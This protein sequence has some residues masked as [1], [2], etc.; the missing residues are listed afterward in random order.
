[1]YTLTQEAQSCLI[2]RD[3]TCAAAR[4]REVLTRFPRRPESMAV[5]ISLAKIEMRYLGAPKDALTHYKTY[6]RRAPSGPLAE[7][8]LFGI[9]EA[10]RH[11][12]VAD[13]EEM[14]LSRFIEQYPESS[15]VQKARARLKQL[16]NHIS[17]SSP[18]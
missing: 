16:R 7:E 12:G 18:S 2:D 1:M 13:K 17:T 5:L 3:W 8:A 9:A 15:L 11:L 10:Y 6:Q 4:Y 14:T